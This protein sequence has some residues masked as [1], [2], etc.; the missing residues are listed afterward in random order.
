MA[1]PT[2][3]RQVNMP[4][5]IHPVDRPDVGI[6]AAGMLEVTCISG[7]MHLSVLSWGEW[8]EPGATS[9]EH[10]GL[11]GKGLS[12]A[13]EKALAWAGFCPGASSPP[14]GGML[15]RL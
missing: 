4:S 8:E 9:L 2:G 14:L 11:S 5:P 10:R 7:L 15:G 3:L 12:A 13:P 6:R 1:A